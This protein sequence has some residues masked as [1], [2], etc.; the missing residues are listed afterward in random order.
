MSRRSRLTSLQIQEIKV[1]LWT[2]ESQADIAREQ[3]VTQATISR[4]YNGQQHL[5]IPWPDG[6]IGAMPEYRIL[7]IL[8]E[9]HPQQ[10]LRSVV[11]NAIL[12]GVDV[13]E[14]AQRIAELTEQKEAQAERDLVEAISTV[15]KSRNRDAD[16][17]TKLPDITASQWSALQSA[18]PNHALVK[19]ADAGSHE[20]RCITFHVMTAEG[21]ENLTVQQLRQQIVAA[22]GFL[23]K[24][25]P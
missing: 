7:E 15:P 25:R 19:E 10:A 3:C 22:R 1:D 17:S 9:R 8:R 20:L 16:T 13:N 11:R 4:I 12:E 2:G 18:F 23:V 21:S 5:Q 24:Q 14:V 6:S